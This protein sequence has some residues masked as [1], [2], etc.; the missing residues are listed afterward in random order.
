M[1]RLTQLERGKMPRTYDFVIV[2]VLAGIAAMVTVFAFLVRGAA[3][4]EAETRPRTDRD[5]IMC[6]AFLD[7]AQSHNDSIRVYNAFEECR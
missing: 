1:N 7:H 2:L 4:I 5:R 3:E 6:A